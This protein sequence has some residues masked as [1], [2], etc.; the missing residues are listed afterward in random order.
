MQKPTN[1][2]PADEGHLAFR[3][4]VSINPYPKD[5]W[6]HNE[7]QLGWD[8]EEQVNPDL[9]DHATEQFYPLKNEE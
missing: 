4:R 3:N 1:M 7:W 2:L 8:I 9:Y 5:D 6:R